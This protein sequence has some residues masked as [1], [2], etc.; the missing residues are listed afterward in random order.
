[1]SS[2]KKE[3]VELFASQL[4]TFAEILRDRFPQ[5][6]LFKR[7]VTAT[8]A[9]KTLCPQKCIKLFIAHSYKYRDDVM[10][11]NEKDLLEHDYT[12]GLLDL[13]KDASEFITADESIELINTLK[14]H[15]FEFD[16]DEKENMWKHMQVLMI[17]ADRYLQEKSKKKIGLFR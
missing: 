6:P 11:K 9:M 15:W 2:L 17:L 4:K 1:M 7:A 12:E 3:T 5:E 14:K 8:I 13:A 10:N 16:E